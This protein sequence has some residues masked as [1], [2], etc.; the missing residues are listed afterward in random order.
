MSDGATPEEA[1]INVQDAIES[2]IEV[3]K[4]WHAIRS[5]ADIACGMR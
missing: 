4:T 2:W 1:V 3:A 5:V